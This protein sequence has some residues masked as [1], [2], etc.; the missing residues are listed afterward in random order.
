MKG[1]LWNLAIIFLEENVECVISFLSTV[2][3]PRF[4]LVS[5][6]RDGCRSGWAPVVAWQVM[7]D[8]HL[9]VTLS[10]EWCHQQC[11]ALA[12][13]FR[14]SHT[15]FS[16]EN[17]NHSQC[18][19]EWAEGQIPLSTFVELLCKLLVVPLFPLAMSIYTEVTQNRMASC[20]ACS[21]FVMMQL[22]TAPGISE[23]T[24]F[25]SINQGRW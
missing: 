17:S 10:I 18:G 3:L 6:S 7:V 24:C 2:N 25:L 11:P 16:T 14:L 5:L 15:G 23:T 13:S 12:M 19:A 21:D 20:F 22:R 4:P 1:Y 9:P 8:R